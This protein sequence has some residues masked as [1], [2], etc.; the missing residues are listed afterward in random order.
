MMELDVLRAAATA[1]LEGCK[2]MLTKMGHIRPMIAL[3]RG[4]EAT[5]LPFPQGLLDNQ[6]GKALLKSVV[7]AVVKK[8]EIDAV[9]MLMDAWK[10]EIG[11]EG[12]NKLNTDA[13]YKREFDDALKRL[14]VRGAAEA[15]YGEVVES[16]VVTVQSPLVIIILSQ[17]YKREGDEI[18]FTKLTEVD[19]ASDTSWQ[20]QG[21]MIFYDQIGGDKQ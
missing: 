15:G 20:A 18:V 19:N 14:G 6:D 17:S 13:T 9:L 3:L 8:L 2:E 1:A 4:N 11:E 10:M 16:I 12:V 7:R 21:A 5:R